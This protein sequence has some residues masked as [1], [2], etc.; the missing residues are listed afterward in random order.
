M[1][2]GVVKVMREIPV[3]GTIVFIECDGPDRDALEK[4]IDQCADYFN[5]VDE[6]FSTYKEQSQVS[7]LRRGELK[8]ADCAPDLQEVWQRCLVIKDITE[9]AF[10]PWCVDGGFDPSG[11]VKGWAS[12]RAIAILRKY[13]AT[14]IQVNGAGDLSLFGGPHKIG[15]RSPDDAKVILKVFELSGGAIATSGTYERGSHIRDPHTSLIAI[16]ARSATVVG[17]DGGMADALAT[18]L[19]VAGRDGAHWF[20]KGELAEYSAWVI[21]RHE[22][23]AWSVGYGHG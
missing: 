19:I 8:I 11:Y 22:D 6:L 20:S 16:G 7:K 9:G 2:G 3:W 15:I 14:L 1:A 13:G 18:A 17:P 21:D 4:G 12:D 23:V 5:Q 10:D